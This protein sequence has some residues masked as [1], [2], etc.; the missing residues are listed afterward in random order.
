VDYVVRGR[1]HILPKHLEVL[2]PETLSKLTEDSLTPNDLAAQNA[3]SA[4][5]QTSGAAAI[6]SDKTQPVVA[7]KS[8]LLEIK[9]KH[10]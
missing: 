4:G 1:H 8:G 3:E 2:G 6:G 5:V 9:T 7:T 10:E